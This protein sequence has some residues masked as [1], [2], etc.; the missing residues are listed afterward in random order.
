M[1]FV[2]FTTAALLT[3][4]AAGAAIF[5]VSKTADT[6]DGTCDADCSLREAV[7]AANASGVDDTV[8]LPAGVYTLTR[9][10]A[11]G[12]DDE[13]AT[14][15]DIE[16]DTQ[17]AGG[18]LTI[19]GAG[20]ATTT[21]DAT[22]LAHRVFHVPAAF[23]AVAVSISGVTLN[24]GNLTGFSMSSPGCALRVAS[25]FV[26]GVTLTDVVVTNCTAGQA[27]IYSHASLVMNQCAIHDNASGG[28]GLN[29]DPSVNGSNKTTTITNTTIARND[30]IGISAIRSV[31]S[32]VHSFN[33]TNVT[34]SDNNQ[35]IPP[36]STI[37]AITTTTVATLKNVTIANDHGRGISAMSDFFG[38]ANVQV[39]NTILAGNARG[40]VLA[41]GQDDAAVLP[42]SLG[43]NVVG[44]TG[45]GAFT[46]P[47][48]QTNTN[49]LLTA[50]GDY[51]GSTETHDLEFG[52]PAIDS[53]AAAA[54]PATD[55]RGIARPLDGD[56]NGIP[57]CDIGAVEFSPPACSNGEDDDGDSL[58]DFPEDKGC[59]SGAD[60]SERASPESELACDDGIDNDGDQLA[61]H[62]AD[63]GCPF[64]W[65]ELE[66]PQCD[67]GID[68]DQ[69]GAT[70]FADSKCQ[71]NWPYWEKT[72]YCGLGAE[73]VLA[74]P[75]LASW[76]RRRGQA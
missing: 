33:L 2:G 47:S 64:S 18:G 71:P 34:L 16:I 3:A 42:V 9:T 15:G 51:G 20:S 10:G 29:T 13:D 7:I 66:D 53:A 22:A 76:R 14:V 44:D 41:I 49:P 43:N 67:D 59:T 24:G 75:L 57:V 23:N 19:Q 60:D 40:D 52:S 74:L 26:T 8:V 27:A 28:I 48:D 50:L 56:G 1:L 21:I 11:A 36:V 37:G 58:V 5:T 12:V 17:Q 69:N 39:Q 6:A 55:Q 62:P 46:Q 65:A 45:S 25:R 38:T 31:A 32:K 63:P 73:L 4:T 30:G 68:N 54:C 61:D 70:D 72:P 35:G